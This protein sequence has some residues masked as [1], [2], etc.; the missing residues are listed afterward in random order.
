MNGPEHYRRAESLMSAAE[1]SEK[2][3]MWNRAG[4]HVARAQVHAT[5]ALAAATIDAP[6]NVPDVSQEFAEWSGVLAPE[7][8]SHD[9]DRSES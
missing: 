7:R 6:R 5:L 3:G 1:Q 2:D 8:G 9:T 4:G